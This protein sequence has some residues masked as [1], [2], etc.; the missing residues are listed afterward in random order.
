MDASVLIV[1][2]GFGGVGCAHVLADHHVDTV[3]VDKN[4]Y[5]QFQPLLYQL[6]TAQIG[7]TDIA[8]PLRGVF[9]KAKSV[10]VITGEVVTIDPAARS[11]TMTDGTTAGGDVLVLAAG[12]QPNF[13]D[14]PGAAE[15]A[16]PLY[17]V[18]DAERLRSRLLGVL[19]SVDR[20]PS[21]V[22]KGG[23]TLVIV[24][25]GATGVESAGAFAEVLRDIVP[26]AYR[27][28]P[29]DQAKVIVVDHGTVVLNGFSERAHKYAAERLEED[30]VE[31]RLGVGV[32]EVGNA[33][34]TLTDGTR[35]PTHMVVWAGG[36]KAAEAIGSSGL[37]C[38]RGGRVDVQPDLTVDGFPGVYV[39][40]DAANITG[41]GGGVLPQLGSVAQQ[42]GRWAAHNILAD[43]EGRPR[44]PFDYHDKGIMA[45]IGRNAAVAELGGKR[46][47]LHGPLAFATWLGV[48]ASLLE[49]TRQKLG[50]LMTWGWD[51]ASK[52]RPHALVDRPDAYAI[53]WTDDDEPR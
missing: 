21:L 18:E 2:G 38:G 45:M 13:F 16:F 6:A 39:V 3:L 27:G 29:V 20:D 51:Y 52:R 28:L 40:G 46:H 49:G 36:E 12:A 47:E 35:I 14:T 10:R 25:A 22:E 41:P 33:H 30:G 42:S 9:Y 17:S 11:V 1:G 37:P 34:V 8:K 19:D 43:L 7:V 26:V 5:H 48:H 44:Q 23:L 4:D 53:D 15:H 32:A 24:G 50:A 31:L